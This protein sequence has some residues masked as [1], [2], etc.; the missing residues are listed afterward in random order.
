MSSLASSPPAGRALDRSAVLLMVLLCAVW[1]LNQVTIKLGNGGISPVMQA[2]LRSVGSV[3]LLLVWCRARGVPL[4]TRDGTLVA[5]MAT[6]LM[7]AA[8]FLIL[9]WGLSYTTASRGVL[10]LYTT[11]FFVA[12]GAHLFLPGDRLTRSKAMGLAAAFVGVMIAFADSL[13][14]PSQRELI[15]DLMCLGAAMLWGGTII[16]VKASRLAQASPEKMLFYQLGLSAVVLPPLS[17]LIGEPGVFAPSATVLLALAYQ[18][19]IVAFASYV[20]WFWLIARFP[21]SRVSAFSFLTPV[22]GVA[23]GGFLLREPL[24]PGLIGALVLI[25]AGI[26]LVNRPERG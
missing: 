16:I 23:F 24:G 5:G 11:P 18:I 13:R 19:V 7:F 17:L 20:A 21:A 14:L 15:G 10:F 2:G 26:Y 8:E 9:Y 6:G 12:V 25:A 4:A 3:V 1:G 22:F